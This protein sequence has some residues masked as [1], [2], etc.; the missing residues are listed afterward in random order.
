MAGVRLAQLM[1]RDLTHGRH[2]SFV[3]G[4]LADQATHMKYPGANF[5]EHMLTQNLEAFRRAAG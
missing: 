4:R 2:H 1:P 3:K 5:R